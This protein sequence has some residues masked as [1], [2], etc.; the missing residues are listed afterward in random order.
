MTQLVTGIFFERLCVLRS[1]LGWQL[2]IN[3]VRRL[4]KRL[5]AS[6]LC[7][8]RCRM[9][10]AILR[11][12]PA[13]KTPA[14]KTIEAIKGDRTRNTLLMRRCHLDMIHCEPI[15]DAFSEYDTGD[16]IRTIGACGLF[17]Y[18]SYSDQFWATNTGTFSAYSNYKL[19]PAWIFAFRWRWLWRRNGR[20]H[21]AESW[22]R[23]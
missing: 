5:R 3:W 6:V 8:M 19:S 7:R 20:R 4:P 15:A 16:P 2:W 12:N 10:S 14:S 13:K 11:K 21:L 17:D 9:L 22:R 23:N 1:K 18:L